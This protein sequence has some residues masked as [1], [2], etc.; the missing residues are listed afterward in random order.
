AT[1]GTDPALALSARSASP[2]R[3]ARKTARAGTPPKMAMARSTATPRPTT[4]CVVLTPRINSSMAALASA[5]GIRETSNGAFTGFATN[6]GRHLVG[7]SRDQA[8]G[9]TN[10]T[11][12]PTSATNAP[13]TISADPA[14]AVAPPT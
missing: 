5:A 11:G 14:H 8:H 4:P 3:K 1:G 2:I 10:N 6:H 9:Q 12:A 7:T 13:M